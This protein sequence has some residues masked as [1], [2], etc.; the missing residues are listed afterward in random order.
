MKFGEK[1]VCHG[2]RKNRRK[3]DTMRKGKIRMLMVLY[4]LSFDR[5][6]YE[7]QIERNKRNEKVE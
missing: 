4:V 1:I 2:K 3:Q 7:I 6:R 5:V